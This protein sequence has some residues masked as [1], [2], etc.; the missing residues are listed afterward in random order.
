[1]KTLQLALDTGRLDLAAA[2]LVYTAVQT[3]NSGG[4]P[5]ED[6]EPFCTPKIGTEI[7]EAK[8]GY[9]AP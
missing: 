4:N 3:M 9:A 8:T 2:T 6:E 5:G 1:M 7:R